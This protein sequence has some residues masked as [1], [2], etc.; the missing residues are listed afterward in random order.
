M[1]FGALAGSIYEAL[2]RD[3]EDYRITGAVQPE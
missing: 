3:T 1:L 2:E